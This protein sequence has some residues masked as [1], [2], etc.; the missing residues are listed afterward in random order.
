MALFKNNKYSKQRSFS[1]VNASVNKDSYKKYLVKA[2]SLIKGA[3]YGRGN[4]TAPEYNLDEI[5]EAS[6]ADSYIKMALMKYSYMLFKAG[7]LLKSENEKASDYVRKRLSIMGF[8]A[9]KPIDILFQEIGDDMIKYSNAFLVKSRVQQIMPGIQAKGFY[10][11]KPVGGYFRID[12]ASITIERDKFGTINKYV[13]TVEGEERKFQPIDVVH[14]YLDKEAANAFGTPRIIAALEDVK[15]LRRIEGN[16]MSMIYRFSMPLFQWI[17]GLP[18]AG[19]QATDKEIGQVRNEIENMSLDGSVVTNE[20]TQI[21]VIGAEGSALSAEGYLKY[22]E[23]RV[24]SALGVS[25]SQMGRG[26]AKQNADSM[27]SQS[28]DTVKHVQKVF[29]IIIENGVINEI[30]LEGGFNPLLNESDRVF[31]VFNEVNIDTKIKVENH[32]M[33]KFQSNMTTF[34]EMRKEIGKTEEADVNELYKN[35]IEVAAE[36]QVAKIKSEESIKIITSTKELELKNGKELAQQAADNAIS[37]TKSTPA[38][39]I[40][41]NARTKSVSPT[42]NGTNKSQKPNKNISNKNTP[43][44]QHGKTSVKVKESLEY[45]NKE[46][47]KK[48]FVNI[49]NRYNKLSN[50]IKDNPDSI[51]ILIPLGYD[52][53]LSLIKIEMQHHSLKAINQS[54]ID[55]SKI[56]GTKLMSPSVSIPL[57]LFEDMIEKDLKK[58]LKDIKNRI[59][60]STDLVN[61][62]SVFVTLEYRLRFMIEY[63]LSKVYWFSYLKSGESYGYTQAHIEFNDSKDSE[64]HSED[65]NIKSLN[66]DEI[67]PFHPFC[68][69]KIYFKKGEK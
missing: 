60:E 31:M 69:C 48:T 2:I 8:A 44:N 41:T 1:E 34:K 24:F 16:I 29:S 28:H 42:G 59:G 14:F 21:K 15:L 65:I 50:D 10:S 56:E 20:K 47:H 5:R 26:A 58:L 49:Y 57:M 22:F 45:K 62:D 9:Q 6:E 51:D 4:L 17:V 35:K 32:E 40:S 63:I 33:A 64:S 12:P 3:G 19:Y 37:T 7:Y 68:D 30:L 52:N 61:I 38:T 53:L 13:Q 66:I 36:E 27:E 54:T 25:E 55:I 46:K 18:Q 43:E 11:D 67:P 39:T 23:Q